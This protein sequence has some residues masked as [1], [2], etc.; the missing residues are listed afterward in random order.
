MKKKLITMLT[1]VA[2]CFTFVSCGGGSSDESPYVGI[3]KATNAS[4]AGLEMS[5]EEALGGEMIFEVKADGECTVEFAGQKESAGWVETDEGFIVDDEVEF[6]V[7]GDKAT[8]DFE[9]V[10]LDLEKQ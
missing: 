5:V 10:L 2:M 4:Y 9:G 3:W 1:V 6:K 7:D 8:V